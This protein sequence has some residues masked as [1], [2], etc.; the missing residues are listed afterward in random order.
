MLELIGWIGG[1][2][3]AL[4]TIPQAI[5]TSRIKSAKDFS[6]TFLFLWTLGLICC[7]IYVWPLQKW[8]L[9]GGYIVNLLCLVVIWRY[10]LFPEIYR[11]Y[12]RKA[13]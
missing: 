12:E 1:V 13:K 10:R 3:L 8:P 4:C 11:N 6:L 9:L 5:E 7:T 2:S